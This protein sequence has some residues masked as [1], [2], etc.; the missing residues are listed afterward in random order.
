MKFLKKERKEGFKMGENAQDIITKTL[1]SFL[2]DEFVLDGVDI[3][4]LSKAIE[5]SLE[6]EGKLK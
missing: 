3:Q 2:D 4:I 1:T 6:K 5:E